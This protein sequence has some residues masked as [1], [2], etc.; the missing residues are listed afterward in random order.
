MAAV[1][2]DD[3]SDVIC[4]WGGDG[5]G[6]SRSCSV[7]SAQCGLTAREI[8]CALFKL[9][10]EKSPDGN[11]IKLSDLRNMIECVSDLSGPFKAFYAHSARNCLGSAKAVELDRRRTNALARIILQPVE[12]LFDDP[13]A[14]LSRVVLPQLVDALRMMLG[15]DLHESLQ[16]RAAAVAHAHRDRNGVTDWTAAI[17]GDEAR[18]ISLEALVAL[19]D[20]F[21]RF[22]LRKDW[23]LLFLN[24]NPATSAVA[25]NAFVV[26]SVEERSRHKQIGDAQF[27]ALMGAL[28]SS[29]HPGKFAEAS[30]IAFTRQFRRPPEA[31]F[32]HLFVELAAIR[33]MN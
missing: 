27:S 26:R 2:H 16:Q 33:K 20:R 17:A 1:A 32:G 30:A 10:E 13:Q 21:R 14:G 6:Q 9:A 3:L 4:Q 18:A 24:T 22:D 29:V 11:C 28:F 5:E 15:C 8:L 31:V 23:F 7:V 19:A 12:W 25:P